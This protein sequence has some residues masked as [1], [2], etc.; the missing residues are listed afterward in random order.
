MTTAAAGL[1]AVLVD[2]G[3]LA[4][5]V[6]RDREDEAEPNSQNGKPSK[7]NPE[8]VACFSSSNTDL[9]LPS[10]HQQST[11]TSPPKN[12]IQPP[13]FAKTPSKNKVPPL[14]KIIAKAPP[15][16]AGFWLLRGNDDGG[17]FVLV[18]EV[19]DLGA[20]QPA[21]S[22]TSGGNAFPRQRRVMNLVPAL[23]WRLTSRTSGEHY[24]KH[25]MASH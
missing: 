12:H 24:Q 22:I 4:V 10:F 2:V 9:Q 18:F 8:K 17:H 6:L 15:L 7:I 14:P 16:R 5:V 11:T 19:E 1:E 25:V 3:A 13:V 20:A 21:A 23:I